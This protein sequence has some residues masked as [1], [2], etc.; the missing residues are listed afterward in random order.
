MTTATLGIAV[1]SGAA[2][3][4]SVDLDKLTASAAR[5]ESGVNQLANAATKANTATQQMS[6][7]SA[8]I[9]A[10]LQDVAVSAQMGMNPLSVALQQGTQLSAVL[11]QVKASGQGVGAALATSFASIVNPLSL[12]TIGAIALGTVALQSLGSLIKEAETATDAIER[13]GEALADIVKGYKAAESAVDDYIESASRLPRSIV[14]DKITKEF[15]TLAREAEDF[16]AKLSQFASDGLF[17]KYGSDAILTLQE[18]ARKYTEGEMSAEE[19][20]FAVGKVTDQLSLLER[21]GA[22]IPGSTQSM[23]DS[24][25]EGARSALAFGDAINQLVAA[26]H[27]LAGAYVHGGT[28]LGL[29]SYIESQRSAEMHQIELDALNA[30]TP[31]QARDIAMR[32]ERLKL[33]DEEITE[34]LREQKIRE[35]GELAYARAQSRIGKAAT[36]DIDQWGNSTRDFQKRIDQLQVEIDL[37]GKGT[38]EI[39][40]QKAAIDL[41]NK[42]KDAGI[43]ITDTVR[44]QIDGLA[45]GVATATAE[46]ER[47]QYQQAQIDA[48]NNTL[49]TGFANL[50]IGIADGSKSAQ[51]SIGDL[52]SSLGRLLINQAFQSL[53]AP[54]A[55]GGGGFNPFGFLMGPGRASGGPVTPGRIYP[56][57]ENTPNTEYFAPAMAGTI[58]TAQQVAGAAGMSGGRQGVD[59]RVSVDRNGN[60]VAI[61][62]QVAADEVDKYDRF[63]V[64]YRVHD[65]KNNSVPV[66]G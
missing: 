22:G 51:E 29:D 49:A 46:L 17:A 10:Q 64:P 23:I 61:A 36:K 37:F 34:A 57:N 13:H 14:L 35:A 6:L 9:A 39:E 25:Q 38:F 8:N 12:V 58:L 59:V 40:K 21:V 66:V 33:V 15:Q 26:S 54:T 63:K 11:N 2:K 55:V 60:L 28:Q 16:Q 62:R 43:P 4:A 5:A 48:L 65:L 31:A 53:F 45:T 3:T 20:Y 19:F 18:L 44:D 1:Q 24:F 27:A 50:F 7:N 56:V 41:L 42:A 47:L 52:L 32:R 30:K